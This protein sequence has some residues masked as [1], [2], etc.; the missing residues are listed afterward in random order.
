MNLFRSRNPIKNLWPDV[1][2]FD[3]INCT[4]QSRANCVNPVGLVRRQVSR[5]Q[6]CSA[7]NK[8][9]LPGKIYFLLLDVE[10]NVRDI[11]LFLC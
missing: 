6:N 5:S 8:S 1:N 7:R 2:V 11:I 3:V 9:W 4:V 10:I